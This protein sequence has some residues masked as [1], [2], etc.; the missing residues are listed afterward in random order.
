[1]TYEPAKIEDL[2]AVYNVVQNTIKKVYPRYYPTEVVDYFCMLHSE[3]AIEND[4]QNGCVSVLKT[5]GIIVGTGSFSDNHIT[6]VYV[7]E[8]HQKKGFGTFIMKKLEEQIKKQYNKAYL[9]ASLPAS[10]FYEKLGYSTV[11]HE[12]QAVENGKVLVYEVMK[13]NLL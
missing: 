12:K 11:R 3:N 6:R 10:S 8:E 4:I 2:Q 1:M 13:K 7:L 5:D 9:D